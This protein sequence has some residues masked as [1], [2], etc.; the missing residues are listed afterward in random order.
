M[1]PHGDLF[2]ETIQPP[3]K[4]ALSHSVAVSSLK[5]CA[6]FPSG[7]LASAKYS[8]ARHIEEHSTR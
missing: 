4:T 3:T 2:G 6:I 5:N 1:I 7:D 8:M